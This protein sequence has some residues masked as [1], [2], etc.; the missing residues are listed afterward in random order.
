[1]K[2]LSFSLSLACLIGLSTTVPAA[3]RP[4]PSVPAASPRQITTLA[5]GWRF[6]FGI[7]GDTPSVPG[8]DDSGWD[9]VTVPHSWNR[10]GTYG[11]KRSP[12]TDNRQGIGWY[13]LTVHSPRTMKGQRQ[14]LDFGAVSKIADVWVNGVHVGTHKGAFARFRFDV[15]A[16]WKPGATNLIAVRAD[17]SK[18]AKDS[19]TAETIPLAGDFFVHGGMYRP[20]ALISSDEAGFDLLDFG[21]PGIYARASAVAADKADISVLA[22]LRNTGKRPRTL[23]LTT[24]IRDAAGAEVARSVQP[25]RLAVG[26]AEQT[27][28]LTLPKP[29]LWNGLADPYGYT[30]V[31]ELTERGRL[32]D[33][34]TQPLGIRTFRFDADKGFFLNGSHV[35]LQGVSRHQDRPDKGWALTPADAAEDMAL[36]KEMGANTIRHAHYQHADEWSDEADKAGMVVWAEL[37]YV[38]SPSMAGGEGSPELWANSEQQLRELIRQNY[39]HPSILMW[40]IGNEV[41]SAEGFGGVIARPLKLLQR[42]NVVAKEEDPYRPTAYADCCEGMDQVK[43]AGEKLAGTADLMGYNRYH[44]WY[45]SRLSQTR[46]KFGEELDRLHAAHPGLPL[47]IS[48]YGAGAAVTQH[49][50][51]IFAGS[52]NPV[53]KPHPEEVQD[54]VHQE[55]WPVIRDRDYVFASWVW[56]MFDFASDL[57]EEGDS[58]DLNNKG[59]VTADRKIKKDA[60]YYYQAQWSPEPMLHLTGKRFIERAYPVTEVKAYSN[61]DRATLQVNG[62][63]I[64]ESACADRICRWPGVRL[65]AGDNR[66]VVT[67]SKSGRAL[68]DEA[69]WNGIDPNQGI[70]I[71]VG[72]LQT[73]TLGGRRFGSD[74]FGTGGRVLVL[75]TPSFGGRRSAPTPLVATE[76]PLYAYWRE[77]P[78]FSYTVPLPDG[79][80]TVK[81]HTFEPGEKTSSM[82]RMAS[83]EVRKPVR[84]TIY[85]DGRPVGPAVDV[86]A[87][88]GGKLRAIAKSYPVTVK[89]GKLRLDFAGADGGIAVVAAIEVTR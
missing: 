12:G 53:G 37:P 6:Q 79:R 5:D 73:R 10:L 26:A 36:I 56:N 82:N 89:G 31:A 77:G 19:S 23:Q 44:G 57:R 14:Y 85:A 22:R 33:R 7:S 63:V 41:D 86:S 66:V 58:I 64:G 50:E 32:V 46:Q 68:R 34:V 48:E 1:V 42:L 8:F 74:S 49:A 43:T 38:T 88:A 29:R 80:W 25:L 84:M 71:D 21:G 28:A 20:V 83:G 4:T 16:Q 62:Q 65:T 13:R 27:A 60:F 11:E 45:Y 78:A 24:T 52:L 72:D 18:V 76:R 17:N 70:A 35:K 61:A 2:S 75:D 81:I 67:A 40:S 47:S 87:E 39:N 59:L 51:D 69:T 3:D 9:K 30:V 15:T 54:Y 55:S